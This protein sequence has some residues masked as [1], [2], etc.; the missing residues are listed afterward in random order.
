MKTVTFTRALGLGVTAVLVTS[1]FQFTPASAAPSPTSLALEVLSQDGA[2]FQLGDYASGDIAVQVKD[3]S[4][5]PSGVNHDVDDS[6]DLAYSWD[7]TSF[8]GALKTLPDAEQATDVNGKF[9]VPLPASEGAGTYTLKAQLGAGTPA[10][11][12]VT[13]TF[14]V[15]NAAPTGSTASISGL[16]AGTPG[17]AKK[18][19][20]TVTDPSSK[21]IAGQVFTL[22]LDHGFFTSGDSATP[23]TL[24]AD[25]GNL[26]QQGA[27]LTAKTDP[28]GQ[29][30]FKAGIAR[31][32]GFDDDAKVTSTVTVSGV[33]TSGTSAAWNTANPLNGDVA[34]RLSP[35]GEQDGPVNPTPAGHRAFYDVFALDQFGNP[36][37]QSDNYF[38][39]FGNPISTPNEDAPVVIDLRNTEKG[40]DCNDCD[41]SGD[42]SWVADLTS[43][44]D[45]WV[46]SFVAGTLDITGTWVE[47]PTYRFDAK[48]APV[49]S[50]ADATS[51]TAS[52]F[53][54]VSFNGSSFSMSSS[55]S[56]TVRVGTTVTQTVRVVDQRGNPIEGYEVRFLRFGPDDVRGDVVATRSTNALGVATYSFIGTRPGRATITAEVTDGT[57]R[58]ELTGTAAFGTAVR[59]RLSKTKGTS[60]GRGAD[61]LTVAAGRATA[62]AR[63][64]LYRVVK[65]VEKRVGSKKLGRKGTVNFTVRDTNRSSRTTYVAVVRSTSKTV[66]DRSNGYKTR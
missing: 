19:T 41:D 8:D 29:I 9:V 35:A 6:R 18:G 24:D 62:G 23:T 50:R 38:D 21:P 40:G 12:Q 47:A 42:D 25:A 15:G 49:S 65:G 37:V 2:F 46:Q 44:G 32:A 56:D 60:A 11:Q 63:V 22:N 54:D 16:G 33:T 17:L 51:T 31:D 5:D 55:V 48:G 10:T 1:A 20:V 3:T 36:V 14:T 30:A 34:I 28:N 57:R 4:T 59:A 26:V 7:Y 58:R 45:I 52:P 27:T 39:E 61:R 64:D 43:F 66:A 13:K 53:Y